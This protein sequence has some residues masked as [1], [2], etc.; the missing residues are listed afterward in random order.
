MRI[1]ARRPDG[2]SPYGR[3]LRPYTP[4]RRRLREDEW[5]PLGEVL[6]GRR[7]QIPRGLL[8]VL[9][10]PCLWWLTVPLLAGYQLARPAR[11]MARRIFPVHPAGH[12]EDTAVRRVQR[13]R[14][15]VAL[16]MS[17]VLLVG[18]GGWQDV[19]DAQAQLLQRLVL[20]PWLALLSAAVVMAVFFCVAR[21]GTRRA[22]R[23][24]LRPAGRSALWY[25]GAWALV[26][27]LF[28]A[29]AK[30]T[31][32][33][34]NSF[35]GKS[36][37][38]LMVVVMFVSFAFWAP[39]WGVIFFLCFAS[40]PAL[41]HAFNLTAV[42]AALP[43]LVTSVL[44]WIF[45]FLGLSTGGLPPGPVPLA[46]GALLGGPVSVTAV[47]WWEIHRLRQRS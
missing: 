6:R 45:A 10:L 36:G 21:P 14:A 29:A 7:E 39:F 27:L 30:G 47:A 22:M 16:G 43:A 4:M 23:T 12:V 26:P 32:L 44:V 8:L 15:W 13:V 9:L 11:R 42:H 18:F 1:D 38:L 3:P 25:F 5:P 33:L 40:A 24:R 35:I 17:V 20:A 2:R 34:P 28:M 31:A 41:R 19:G 37:L 46:V